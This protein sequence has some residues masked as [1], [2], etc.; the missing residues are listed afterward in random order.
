MKKT[1]YF[2][3]LVAAAFFMSCEPV[4]E[5]AALSLEDYAAVH[6]RILTVDTHIDWPSRQLRSPDFDPGK[7][8]EPGG[9]Q[10][11]Q[12]DLVRMKEGG[13]DATFMSIYTGQRE[14]S[15][16]GDEGAKQHALQLIEITNK[17]VADYPDLA[18]IALTADD[19]YRIEKAGKRA[20][21]M[22]MENGW[23]IGKDIKNVEMFY[24]L[25]VRYVTLSHSRNN[26]I[27]DSSTDDELEWGGLSPFGEEVVRE[28]NRLG[29]LVDISHVHDSTF[30]DVMRITK[31]PVVASHSSARAM[32]D[33][34]RNMNDDLLRLVK[35]NNGVVQLCLLG[36]YI[37]QFPPNEE[38]DA[39]RRKVR[40]NFRRY[41]SGEMSDEEK[42]EFEQNLSDLR[43]K[44]PRA[45]LSDAVDHIDHMVKVMGID[46][47]GIGSD[48]DGGGGL[49]NIDDVSEMPNITK[50]LIARGYSEE[51][52]RKI[53]GGNL[54]RV[55]RDAMKVAE[56]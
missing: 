30:Y 52:I 43:N 28:M 51:D 8:Y 29:M 25:G 10:S 53:W 49:A 18:E 27:A 48:F 32:C 1:F 50:E 38:R 55:M 12:W 37:K 24:N 23:P 46:H 40:S 33:H 20:I 36:N 14:R 6:D 16:E 13:L 19:A 15:P 21:F 3:A 42:A 2:L 41:G 39:L 22:G 9:M 45:S 7:R 35:E 5:Q 31:A 4:S 17:M 44:F 34:P 56:K 26:D 47:I 54:M 11:G